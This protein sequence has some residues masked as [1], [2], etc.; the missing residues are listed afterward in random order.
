MLLASAVTKKDS[1]TFVNESQTLAKALEIL[2]TS[3]NRCVPILDDSNLFFRGNIYKMHLYRHKSQGGDMSLPVTYLLK[4]ATKFIYEDASPFNIL[5]T[6]RD[7]P[8]IAVLDKHQNFIGILMHE[9]MLDHYWYALGI[10]NGHCLLT[11]E[12]NGKQSDLASITKIVT[13]Y[14][15]LVN[16]LLLN[17]TTHPGKQEVLMTLP[18]QTEKSVIEN[19]TKRLERKQFESFFVDKI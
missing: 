9:K 4:N 18:K 14:S 7:L 15:A 6:L 16:L 8:Y 12:T 10:E 17:S 19:I 3:N 11:V 13:K 5:F 2:E 1:L